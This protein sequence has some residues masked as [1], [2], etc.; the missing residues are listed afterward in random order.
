MLKPGTSMAAPEYR[1]VICNKNNY[2]VAE[3]TY[4]LRLSPCKDCP[5]HTFTTSSGACGPSPPAP[6][7]GDD[8][9]G[10]WDPRACCTLPGWGYDG[11]QAAVCAT[12]ETQL[13][14]M[15]CTAWHA[16]ASIAKHWLA[17]YDWSLVA[18]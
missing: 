11:V 7:Y 17:A 13:W 2:G 14:W 1:S 5:L 10:Y 3:K 12:G 6:S 4:E 9:A 16:A 8:S 15:P 18:G